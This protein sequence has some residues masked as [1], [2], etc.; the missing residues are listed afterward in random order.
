[1]PTAT[2]RRPSQRRSSSETPA[3]VAGVRLTHPSRPLWPAIHV[4]K[5]QLAKFYEG[6]AELIL[7]HVLN[8]P[9]TLVRCP[10][11]LS[12]SCFFMKHSSV[13]AP[14]A[15]RRLDIQEKKKVGEYLVIESIAGVIALVQ[16]DVLEI[17][18]WNSTT[19]NLEQPNRIIIDLDPGPQVK[20]AE[21]V[22]TAHLTRQILATLKLQSFVK[23]TGGV[24]LHVVAPLLPAADWQT[25]ASFAEAVA[26]ALTRHAPRLYTVDFKKAGRERKILIDY[27]RN[28][29][30]NTAV[31]AFSTR[32]KPQAP[33]SV[34]LS[35]EELTP[36]LRSDQFTILNLHQRLA[37]LRSDPWKAYWRCRQQISAAALAAVQRLS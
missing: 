24:G 32:A 10:T 7:P 35:W 33:V 20:W 21:V 13:W 17:H 37:R 23:T 16:M 2:A 34:P 4:T 12:G 14:A 26:Q 22:E 1:M 5:L 11:G 27:R 8:R 3:E 25:C 28:H 31:A 6:I 36:K 15:L 30:A 18:T 9:L 29:R 19:A